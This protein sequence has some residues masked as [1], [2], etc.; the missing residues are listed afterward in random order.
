MT[1]QDWES[2]VKLLGS[3]CVDHFKENISSEANILFYLG[4]R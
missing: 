3:Y 2:L 1:E 4:E